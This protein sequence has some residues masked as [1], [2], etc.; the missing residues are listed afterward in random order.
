MDPVSGTFP[1]FGFFPISLSGSSCGVAA[2]SSC[3]VLALCPRF[4]ISACGVFSF[5][6][7]YA[8]FVL[9]TAVLPKR[10]YK[11]HAPCI[12]YHLVVV[13][14]SGHLAL[15]ALHSMAPL[16]DGL[17][18]SLPAP[19]QPIISWACIRHSEEAARFLHYL[20]QERR[21]D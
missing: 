17:F 21:Q 8:Y 13:M 7:S 10:L 1:G 11:T 18:F 14:A 2:V 16:L 5:S 3:S 20:A 9:F 6:V 4:L 19:S 12:H 15:S